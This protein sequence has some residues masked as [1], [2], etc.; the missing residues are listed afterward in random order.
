M[1]AAAA[2]TRRYARALL[3]RAARFLPALADAP[4]A[5]AL[6]AID[7]FVERPSASRFLAANRALGGALRD[8]FVDATAPRRRAR[9]LGALRAAGLDEPALARLAELPRDS[10]I[11][12]RLEALGLLA[13]ARHEISGRAAAAAAAL[14]ALR[15][16]PK[17]E[18][19]KWSEI[20][21]KKGPRD[22][23]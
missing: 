8:R 12:A 6:R 5:A 9:G 22:E 17:K 13:L 16:A 2:D 23:T 3:P 11:A 7:D 21:A 10:R 18:K 15:D 14:R 19:P 4:R 20:A 1:I